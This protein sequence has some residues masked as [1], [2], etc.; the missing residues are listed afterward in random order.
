MAV[1]LKEV[2]AETGSTSPLNAVAAHGL[3]NVSARAHP[4][5]FESLPMCCTIFLQD[6][7][8]SEHES[9]RLHE[10]SRCIAHL[11]NRDITALF[12]GALSMS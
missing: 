1:L 9:N 4:F 12:K 7:K 2:S 6:V 11:R 3:G 5:K 10:R 8:T